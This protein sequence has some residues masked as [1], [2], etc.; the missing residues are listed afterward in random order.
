MVFSPIQLQRFNFVIT[1]NSLFLYSYRLFVIGV[2]QP[3]K[4]K[5]Q[6]NHGHSG[7]LTQERAKIPQAGC[8]VLIYSKHRLRNDSVGVQGEGLAY[9]SPDFEFARL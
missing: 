7:R 1:Y 8:A 9:H 5:L 4:P 2:R 3:L 6:D